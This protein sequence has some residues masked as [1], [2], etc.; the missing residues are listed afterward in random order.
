MSLLFER[1][2][3]G[4]PACFVSWGLMSRRGFR[5]ELW[6]PERLNPEVRVVRLNWHVQLELCVTHFPHVVVSFPPMPSSDDHVSLWSVRL[7][8]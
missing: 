8:K 6:W 7:I 2:R 3:R 1:N 4:R 5:S